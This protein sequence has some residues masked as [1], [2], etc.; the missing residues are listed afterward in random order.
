MRSGNFSSSEIYKLIKEGRAKDAPFSAAGLTYIKEKQYEQRLGRELSNETNA[1]PTSWGNLLELYVW[2]HK[3]GLNDYRF[4][5]KQRYVH[6]S[7]ANWTGCP[8]LVSDEKVADIKCPFTLKAF[9]DVLECFNDP[10]KLKDEKPEYY[11][12]LVSNAIL[13]EKATAELI[14]YAPY[15]EDLAEIRLFLDT[16]V[17]AK[18]GLDINKFSF[19]NWAQDDDLPHLIKGNHYIDLNVMTFEIPEADKELLFNRVELATKLLNQ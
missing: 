2:E 15:L 17:F 10:E 13:T 1:K 7:N 6:T 12:Q 3:I 4:E 19:L 18:N 9:C 5:H 14:V 8:D 16:D 11:W